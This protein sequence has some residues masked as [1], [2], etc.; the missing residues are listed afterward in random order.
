MSD[1]GTS[2]TRFLDDVADEN[3]FL[4][5]RLTELQQQFEA[6]NLPST[7]SLTVR[8]RLT[9]SGRPYAPNFIFYRFIF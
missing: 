9:T 3:D 5:R 1:S 7:T 8:Q 4:R 6:L 2:D